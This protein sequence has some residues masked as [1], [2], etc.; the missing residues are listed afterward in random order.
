ME[1]TDRISS[2]ILLTRYFQTGKDIGI[3]LHV[4]WAW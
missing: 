2:L 4:L 1:T 3:V